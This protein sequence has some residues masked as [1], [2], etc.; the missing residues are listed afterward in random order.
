VCKGRCRWG[1]WLYNPAR[2][3]PALDLLVAWRAAL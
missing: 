1:D 2:F 3:A